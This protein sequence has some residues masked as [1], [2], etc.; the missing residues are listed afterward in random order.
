M[1]LKELKIIMSNKSNGIIYLVQPAELV[2]TNRYKVGCSS[3]KTLDRVKKGYKKG[4]RY[5]HISECENPFEIESEIKKIFNEKYN[6]IAGKEYFEVDNESNMIEVFTDI[7]INNI[8]TNMKTKCLFLSENNYNCNCKECSCSV[9]F[10]TETFT[11]SNNPSDSYYCG[12]LDIVK[13]FILIYRNK[14]DK[15]KE[16]IKH[17]KWDIYT[18]DLAKSNKNNI[19][20]NEQYIDCLFNHQI[21]NIIKSVYIDK[22][23]PKILLYGFNFGKNKCVQLLISL[24]EYFG[25]D[26]DDINI[27]SEESITSDDNFSNTK[28][29]FGYLESH[30][31]IYEIQGN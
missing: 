30:E 20:S 16:Y 1:Y 15:F 24:F 23:Y 22:T 5:L 3:N 7:V 17:L 6:L 4:T 27:D 28:Y 14:K 13:I 11:I 31:E 25:Y 26:L 29:T 18:Y 19:L 2:G 10:R 21:F 9:S 12:S 8:K